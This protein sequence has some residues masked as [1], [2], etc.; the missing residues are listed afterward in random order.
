MKDFMM[1]WGMI[2]IGVLMNVFGIYAVKAKMNALG[3]VELNSIGAVLCYFIALAKSPMAL[4]GAVL[5]MADPIPYAI[6][7]SRMELSV[8]YPVSIALN[9]LIVLPLSVVF[10]GEA[11]NAYKLTG[12]GL[13]I[14]SI[15]FLYK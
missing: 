11:M 3:S 10:L 5:V 2:S 1:S 12:I 9:F 4:A 7:L 15:Y 6:A 8:A 14:L 13:I